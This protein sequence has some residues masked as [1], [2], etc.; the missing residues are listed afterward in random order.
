M[1]L[2]NL[3]KKDLIITNLTQKDREGILQEMIGFLKKKKLISDHKDLFKKLLEREKQVTTAIADGIA[4]PHC[5]SKEIEESIIVL[6]I[7]KE[8]ANFNSI[9]GKPTH[10]FFLVIS[11]LELSSHHLQILALVA[12]MAKKGEHLR[13]RLLK[14]E[15][16]EEIIKAIREEETTHE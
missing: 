15:S 3:L 7:S 16:E 2:S 11:P 5:K 4:I 13:D 1:R 9:N 10:I 8:G 14:K 12:H 6:G